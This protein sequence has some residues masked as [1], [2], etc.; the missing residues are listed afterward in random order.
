MSC[1][2]WVGRRGGQGSREGCGRAVCGGVLLNQQERPPG[3]HRSPAGSGGW[4]QEGLPS[5]AL[6]GPWVSGTW[7]TVTQRTSLPA[8]QAPPS[9][10]P[11]SSNFHVSV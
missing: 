6:A 3:T 7:L 11:H 9:P 2:A 5:Q 10:A 8:F 4:W 1:R